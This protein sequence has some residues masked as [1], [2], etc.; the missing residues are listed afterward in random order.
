MTGASRE[1]QLTVANAEVIDDGKLVENG[2]IKEVVCD[3]YLQKMKLSRKM[4]LFLNI[5]ALIL[6]CVFTACYIIF[7]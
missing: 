2:S 7:A 6:L 5:N 1:I 3:L 4:N